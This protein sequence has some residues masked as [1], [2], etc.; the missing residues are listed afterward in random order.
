VLRAKGINVV[1]AGPSKTLHVNVRDTGELAFG[2]ADRPAHDFDA[3][4]PFGSGEFED[5][6]EAKFRE[7][8]CD[9]SEF[10]VVAS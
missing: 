5:L 4:E 2:L 7:D 9:E 3:R 10:H 1:G 6:G 8:G